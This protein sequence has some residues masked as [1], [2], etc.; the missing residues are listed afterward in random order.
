M[1]WDPYRILKSLAD[2]QDKATFGRRLHIYRIKFKRNQS[3]QF[4]LDRIER[5]AN[6]RR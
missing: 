1:M 5:L 6:I 2:S 3:A 4:Y